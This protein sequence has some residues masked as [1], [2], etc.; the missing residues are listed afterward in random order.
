MLRAVVAERSAQILQRARERGIA[1]RDVRPDPIEQLGLRHDPIAMA[2]QVAEHREGFAGDRDEGFCFAKLGPQL[3][4]REA[5]RLDDRV[6][7]ALSSGAASGSKATR[8]S[9]SR[10][11]HCGESSHRS[12]RNRKK[13]ARSVRDP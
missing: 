8:A 1:D 4:L 2:R 11:C 6:G 3:E 10:A 12:R 5:D 7:L 9:P 13:P